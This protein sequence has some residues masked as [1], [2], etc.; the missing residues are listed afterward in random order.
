[1]RATQTGNPPDEIAFNTD[2]LV[3]WLS[4][5]NVEN[6]VLDITDKVYAARMYPL[7]DMDNMYVVM[8]V[9]LA[10]RND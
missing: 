1:V 3:E 6:V 5:Q 2:Y 10:K 8:P 9:R 7:N 4:N